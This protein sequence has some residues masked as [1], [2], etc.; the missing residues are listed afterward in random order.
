MYIT[1]L[2][3]SMEEKKELQSRLL[4]YFSFGNTE[5][6]AKEKLKC[7]SEDFK[8]FDFPLGDNVSKI[9]MHIGE[10]N[11]LVTFSD[12]HMLKAIRESISKIKD[13]N[14]ENSDGI[15]YSKKDFQVQY[16]SFL[17]Q[18]CKSR[19]EA[20]EQFKRIAKDMESLGCPIGENLIGV[21][22]G[23]K[24]LQI[25]FSLSMTGV[26]AKVLDN[27]GALKS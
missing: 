8:F 23:S 11:T 22:K 17:E 13:L 12:M 24:Q 1:V 4:R 9:N 5:D 26:I 16:L 27:F 20:L 19:S 25:L 15:V 7:L 6:K 3:D 18:N 21:V 2:R 10:F 14:E